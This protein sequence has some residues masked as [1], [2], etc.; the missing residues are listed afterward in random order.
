MPQ[1][2]P[3]AERKSLQARLRSQA[4]EAFSGD[5]RVLNLLEGDWKE[6]DSG[7][8][9]ESPIDGSSLGPLPMIELDTAIKAVQFAKSESKQWAKVDLDERRRRVTLCLDGLR[10]QRELIGLLLMWE[11]GKP[12]AQAM[13]DIDRCISGVG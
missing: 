12:Y 4:A 10:E 13:T 11:I 5:G 9:Y 3:I 7:R 6:P 1:V 8:H 2:A